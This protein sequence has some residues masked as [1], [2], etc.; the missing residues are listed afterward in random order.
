M[1][2]E[3]KN[4]LAYRC[5]TASQALSDLMVAFGYAADT[6]FESEMGNLLYQLDTRMEDI[7]KLSQE[8]RTLGRKIHTARIRSEQE[9]AA[10]P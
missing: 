7:Q 1:R 9:P 2:Q 10:P 3:T 8:L 4:N 5:T 6:A